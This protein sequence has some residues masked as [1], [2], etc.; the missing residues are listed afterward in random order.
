MQWQHHSCIVLVSVSQT[1]MVKFWRVA[2]PLQSDHFLQ[3]KSLSVFF[4][5]VLLTYIPATDYFLYCCYNFSFLL[6]HVKPLLPHEFSSDMLLAVRVIGNAY[7]ILLPSIL[8]LSL[9]DS[10]H[11]ETT[12]FFLKV[13]V[14]KLILDLWWQKKFY[15]N[16]MNI[17]IP[18]RKTPVFMYVQ[19][20]IKTSLLSVLAFQCHK[21]VTLIT[22]ALRTGS[23]FCTLLMRFLSSN[24]ATLAAQLAVMRWHG[25]LPAIAI[26]HK[27]LLYT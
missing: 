8:S 21:C 15:H 26:W 11:L 17:R 12:V 10:G 1:S 2:L 9:S 22:A 6:K 25:V 18:L 27:K 4:L 16:Y 14:A 7:R 3:G 23:S 24:G 20:Y 5:R 13:H 19:L